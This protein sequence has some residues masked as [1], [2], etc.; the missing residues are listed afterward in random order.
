MF[1][2]GCEEADNPGEWQQSQGGGERQ[3]GDPA[4]G[5]QVHP[6][7][8]REEVRG[9]CQETCHQSKTFCIQERCPIELVTVV[10]LA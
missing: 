7:R 10:G 3:A 9:H 1:T 4:Q 6:G 5:R 2:T 8:V